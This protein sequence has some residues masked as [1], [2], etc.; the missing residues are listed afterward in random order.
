MTVWRI[1]DLRLLAVR[2]C[3]LD[4]TI[5]DM[6]DLRRRHRFAG[7]HH[8]AVAVAVVAAGCIDH[9]V[10]D[11]RMLAVG[12]M[13]AAAHSNWNDLG[14]WKRHNFHIGGLEYLVGSRRVLA[15][16]TNLVSV[17]RQIAVSRNLGC[18][19]IVVDR[20]LDRC[21]CCRTEVD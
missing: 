3:R 9:I 8:I 4:S 12:H 2:L 14:G 16:R 10:V 17:V 13:M 6:L 18:I 7:D 11:L 19:E 21:N 5:A 15:V 1:G 20:H